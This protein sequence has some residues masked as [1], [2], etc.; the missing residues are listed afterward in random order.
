[1]HRLVV[2]WNRELNNLDV[3][4][5]A[6]IYEKSVAAHV[7]TL[8]VDVPAAHLIWAVFSSYDAESETYKELTEPLNMME[9][10]VGQYELPI[11]DIVLGFPTISVI[12][13]S[14]LMHHI[15]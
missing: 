6:R 7:L 10:G 5:G 1:M 13:S 11:P 3:I 8:M 12:L 9:S 15:A 4:S 14:V 2:K